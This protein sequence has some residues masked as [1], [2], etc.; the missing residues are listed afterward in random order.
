MNE[1][2]GKNIRRMRRAQRVRTKLRATADAPRLSVARSVKHIQAQIID[3][4][5]GRTLAHA[6]T[7]S[8]TMLD[9]LKGKKKSERAAVIGSEIAK[10]AK[11]AGIERVVF[12]RGSARFHGR[13]KALADA[14]RAGGLQF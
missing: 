10:K 7:T 9:A 14:A 13:I 3:D 8:K 5:T 2:L 4:A 12:D 1:A 6:T 11:A